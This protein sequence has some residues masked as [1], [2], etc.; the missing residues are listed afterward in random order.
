MKIVA[1]EFISLDG[2]VEYADRWMGEHSDDQLI[3]WMNAQQSERDVIILGRRTYQEMAGFWPGQ[4][5]SNPVAASMNN[6]PKVVVSST[7]QSVDEWQNSTLIG[8]NVLAELK[9]LKGRPGR[10]AMI[11]GSGTLIRSLLDADLIDEVVLLVFPVVA[12]EGKRLFEGELRPR[13]LTL[14]G[15]ESFGKGVVRLSYAL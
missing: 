6:T 7:L 4:G 9:R 1:A 5:E 15:C 13:K 2:V 8:K 10:N 12:G 3:Q 14:K 11:I